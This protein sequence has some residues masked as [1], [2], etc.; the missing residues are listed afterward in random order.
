MSERMTVDDSPVD[1]ARLQHEAATWNYWREDFPT[2]E[3]EKAVDAAFARLKQAILDEGLK[4]ERERV[5][6]LVS[7]AET[8]LAAIRRSLEY[9]TVRHEAELALALHNLDAALAAVRALRAVS[10]TPVEE[11]G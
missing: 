1:L 5:D 2:A 8:A 6:G 4:E 10:P 11:G 9:V 3:Q 7:A